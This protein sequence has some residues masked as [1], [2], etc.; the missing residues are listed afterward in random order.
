MEKVDQDNLEQERIQEAFQYIDTAQDE[1]LNSLRLFADQPSCSREP[2]VMPEMV[3]WL[4]D[5]LKQQGFMVR[6]YESG[7]GNAPVIT[8][9]L[10]EVNQT[11]PVIFSGHY[12]TALDREAIRENPFRI[13]DGKIFG[14]GVLDMKS[15]IILAVYAAKAAVAAGSLQPIRIL[16][17]GDEEINHVGADTVKLL[18]REAKGARCAF[19]MESGLVSNQLAVFRKGGTRCR[20]RV[21]GVEMHVGGDFA[22]GR[23]AIVEAAHKAIKISMLTNLK[24]GTTVNVGTIQG[25]TIFNVIPGHCEFMVDI[26]FESNA[27]YE[28]ARQDLERIC[29]ETVIEGTT[30]ELEFVDVMY[31]FETTPAGTRLFEFIRETAKESGFPDMEPIRLGGSSDAAALTMAGV[32][33]VCACGGRGEGNHTTKEYIE[34]DSL[35]QR[36]KL[37]AAAILRIGHLD[38]RK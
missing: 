4:T 2:V 26:R 31:T 17:A 36:A 25:G 19:N 12:D 29:Q 18:M 28:K 15:G 9:D 23:N 34:K 38:F 10:G 24:T 21:T 11:S 3:T 16:L 27:E 8:A 5:F 35:A 20:I 22:K 7:G 30:T 13:E 33:V 6:T 32:P 37:F 14:T 1:M